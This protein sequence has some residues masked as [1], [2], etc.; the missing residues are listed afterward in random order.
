[1][2]GA[3]KNKA[4]KATT[5]IKQLNMAQ[6]TNNIKKS[7]VKTQKKDAQRNNQKTLSKK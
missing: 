5:K 1:M 2:K 7:L 6:K 3:R 4:K